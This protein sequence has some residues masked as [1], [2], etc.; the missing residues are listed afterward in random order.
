MIYPIRSDWS[1][2]VSRPAQALQRLAGAMP[3]SGLVLLS[4]F[5]IQLASVF[6]KSMFETL[7]VVGASFLYKAIAALFL[8]ATC[9][10][11]RWDYSRRSYWLVALMGLTIAGMSLA[12][13]SAIDR[14]P[15]GV[16]STLEFLGP[17][18]VAILGSRQR[19][20]FLW[21]GLATT[22]VLLFNP[23]HSMTLDPVGVALALI[24][25][26][27]W[28]CYI[29][30]SRAVGQ[31]FSGKVGLTLAMTIA[32]L[33]LMPFGIGQAGAALL[34]PQAL[35]IGLGVAILGAVI[36]YS[37][38]FNA[39]KRMPPRVFG[40]LMSIEPAIAALVGLL[41][42][43]EVLTM[44]SVVAVALVTLAAIGATLSR[45]PADS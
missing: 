25:G 32:A 26:A 30:L 12:I 10:F 27:C 3:P 7:G 33:V 42:L 45:S 37:L 22:G 5:A 44:R 16:A 11:Y 34:S 6:A 23:L 35:A 43:H 4:S 40:V 15:L 20:D 28:A 8:L 36:P 17:L 21:A 2:A 41:F 14:I 9:R 18:S 13:Y 38:E 31:A 39:L 29:L 24:A 19:L 1:V